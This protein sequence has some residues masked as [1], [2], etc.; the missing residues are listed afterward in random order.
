MPFLPLL[1]LLACNR[2]PVAE[3]MPELHP[4]KLTFTQDGKPLVD[5]SV[6]LHPV[7]PTSRWTGGGPTG[8]DG[9]CTVRTHG[10]FQGLGPGEYRITV[11]K[12]EI[13]EATD[14]AAENTPS[15][16]LV[17]P[18]YGDPEKSDLRLT[19]PLEKPAPTFELGLPVRV[20]IP[21]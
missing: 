8:P 6:Q 15:F 3:D 9:S 2:A 11:S 20:P 10:R 19:V 7:D 1:L 18:K 4:V 21:M 13:T 12:I 14:P 16:D 17:D 5:A